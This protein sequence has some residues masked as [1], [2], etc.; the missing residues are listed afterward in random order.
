MT[1]SAGGSLASNNRRP[2]TLQL[3]R[4]L[5]VELDF[6]FFP[7][8]CASCGGWGARLCPTRE[9]R[10]TWLRDPLRGRCGTPLS[11]AL[12]ARGR[13]R[14]RERGLM[15]ERSATPFEGAHP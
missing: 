8:R 2:N 14:V 6:V 12:P 1:R 10:I 13:T 9:L 4:W 7:P 5:W 15:G 3:R 11:G